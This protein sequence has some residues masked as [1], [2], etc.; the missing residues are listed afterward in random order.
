MS[1]FA[2]LQT[3]PHFHMNS[4][5]FFTQNRWAFGQIHHGLIK[6]LW[7][8]RIYSNLLDW[9]Q[10]YTD[11]EFLYLKKRYRL[12][13]TTPEAVSALVHKGIPLSQIVAVAH[14][15][16]DLVLAVA[17]SG[18]GFFNHLHGFGVV[19]PHLATVAMGLGISRVPTDVRVGI[20]VEHY[21][22]ELPDRLLTVGYAG[23]STA[24]LSDGKDCKRSHLVH[25][26]VKDLGITLKVHEYYNHLAMPGYYETLDALL[27]SSSYETAGMPG[28]EAAAA[29]RLVISTG[30]GYFDG[31]H[32]VLCRTDEEGFVA[33]AR[34][35]LITFSSARRAFRSACINA[36]RVAREQYDW[37][38]CINDW[39][40]L[41][42]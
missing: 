33:D 5:L 27:V 15:E 41:F 9:T 28:M 30:V 38:Y 6:R 22:M 7:E 31:A 34:S 11:T 19:N 21:R 37:A 3:R 8:H 26:A 32:G 10:T 42:E 29:G 4:V 17:D 24:L 40:D 2:Q 13:C 23:E 25:A 35:A 1:G 14:C 12:F 18:V 39:V 36:R 16:R 20:D